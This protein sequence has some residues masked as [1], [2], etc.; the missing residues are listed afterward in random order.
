M[1]GHSSTFRGQPNNEHLFPRHKIL[2]N[3]IEDGV[4]R[5]V[6]KPKTVRVTL[7]M[8]VLYWIVVHERRRR[9]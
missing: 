1:G 6:L 7:A 4:H 2:L 9:E 5:P 8:I 3:H